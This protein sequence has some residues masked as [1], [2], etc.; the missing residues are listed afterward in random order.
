STPAHSMMETTEAVTSGPMPSPGSSVILCCTIQ[1]SFHALAGGVEGEIEGEVAAQLLEVVQLGDGS[2]HP[3]QRRLDE[4]EVV[5]PPADD[6]H[7]GPGA[8]N[9]DGALQQRLEVAQA[10]A[11]IGVA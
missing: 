6:G 2:P 3:L 7:L 10:E 9:L 8:K 5:Q 1:Q 4:V 11:G